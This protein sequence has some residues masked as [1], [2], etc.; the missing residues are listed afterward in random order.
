[1]LELEATN[2]HFKPC[3]VGCFWIDFS[4]PLCHFFES[5]IYSFR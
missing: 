1:M 3:A 2:L 5:D 4:C